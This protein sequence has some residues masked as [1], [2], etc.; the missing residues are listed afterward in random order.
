MDHW[1]IRRKS[2]KVI[3]NNLAADS[4]R[5]S[6]VTSDRQIEVGKNA[7]KEWQTTIE[8]KGFNKELDLV[9]Q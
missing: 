9:I 3:C 4:V 8:T 6:K 1:T 5:N 7:P 2:L